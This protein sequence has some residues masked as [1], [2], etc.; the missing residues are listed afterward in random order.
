MQILTLFDLM[1]FET[2]KYIAFYLIFHMVYVTTYQRNICIRDI[3]VIE[4]R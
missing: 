3:G 1:N 2:Q 4:I